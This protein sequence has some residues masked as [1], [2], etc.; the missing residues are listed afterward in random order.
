MKETREVYLWERLYVM[1]CCSSMSRYF[2]NIILL[3][4]CLPS[5][6][7]RGCACTGKEGWIPH[8]GRVNCLPGR[9]VRGCVC[10]GKEG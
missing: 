4:Y 3:V 10:T 9:G 8:K 6:G 5:K 2:G 1:R 7:V